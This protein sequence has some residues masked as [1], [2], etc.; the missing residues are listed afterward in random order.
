MRPSL[1]AAFYDRVQKNN[2]TDRSDFQAEA[3]GMVDFGCVLPGIRTR[4]QAGGL[5]ALS[6][7]LPVSSPFRQLSVDIRKEYTDPGFS[8]RLLSF[9]SFSVRELG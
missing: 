5:A 6:C 1:S 4:D 7:P 2:P 3:D 8:V 9:I